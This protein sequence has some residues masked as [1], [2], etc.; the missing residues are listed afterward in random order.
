M[1]TDGLSP[2][3][4]EA[5]PYQGQRAGLVSRVV[6]S[7]VDGVT[8]AIV[9]CVGYLG[10]AGLRFLVSPRT[11]SFPDASLVTSFAAAATVCVVYLTGC[12]WL[13]GRTYGCLIMGLRV[14]N[15]RGGRVRLP[16]ALVRALLCTFFP[17]G[18]LWVAVS[19]DNRSAQDLVLRTSVV[20][21][22]TPR[23]GRPRP[24]ARP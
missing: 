5:R 11:F 16:Q 9:L 19:C 14:V 7:A 3:P 6:A 12:W 23:A 17:L 13:S 8:V 21:D 20:Y 1:R 24:S 15:H 18:L 2:L 4:R 10:V 22:W